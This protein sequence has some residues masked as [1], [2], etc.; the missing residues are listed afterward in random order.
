MK[1]S[2]TEAGQTNSQQNALVDALNQ[3]FALFKRNYHNQFFKAYAQEADVI[4][5][6][7]LWLETLRS[8]PAQTVLEASMAIVKSSEFLPTLKT[9]LNHCERLSNRA[10]PDVHSAYAEACNAASPKLE[11]NWSHPAV[12]FAGRDVGWHFLQSNAENVA[13]PVFKERYLALRERVQAGE[14]LILPKPEIKQQIEYKP[15]SDET[16]RQY[17]EKMQALFDGDEAGGAGE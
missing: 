16:S 8:F 13:L 1:N 9:M 2:P 15:A 3:S 14:Q 12:Y 5:V 7:R 11:Q 6:K 10:L 4:A 17:M